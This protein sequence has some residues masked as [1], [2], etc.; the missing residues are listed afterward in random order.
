MERV[1]SSDVL[2]PGLRIKM[3]SAELAKHLTDRAD[4]HQRRKEE[5][6]ALLPALQEAADK[7]KLQAPAAV[8]QFNKAGMSN[9]YRFDGDDAIEQLKS[10]IETHNNK[11]LAFRFLAEHLFEQDYCLD[12]SDLINLEILK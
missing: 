12:R 1:W 5:K 2:V 3:P 8:A 6:T 11:A 4:Y 9:S 7:I 10:D